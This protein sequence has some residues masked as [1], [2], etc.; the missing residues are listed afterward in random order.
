MKSQCFR[1]V[2]A[3]AGYIPVVSP[4]EDQ[5]TRLNLIEEISRL[6]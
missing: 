5:V 6:F 1:T 2:M 3:P 4:R